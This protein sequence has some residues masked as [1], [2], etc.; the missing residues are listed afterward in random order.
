[1]RTR[2]LYGH[3]AGLPVFAADLG[4]VEMDVVIVWAAHAAA[5]D[6]YP[7]NLTDHLRRG[8]IQLW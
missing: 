4:C 5:A 7:W 6:A 8:K 2:L 1:M 3:V